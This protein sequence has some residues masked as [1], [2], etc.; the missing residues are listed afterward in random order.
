MTNVIEFRHAR[1]DTGNG[2]LHDFVSIHIDGRSLVEIMRELEAKMAEREGHPDLAGAYQPFVKPESAE[3]HYLGKHKER[4]GSSRT[5]TAIL[6]CECGCPG[7]WPLLC[8]IVIGTDEV[9]WIDFEQ[10]HRGANSKGSFWDYSSFAGFKFAKD[11]YLGSLAA[12]ER[13]RRR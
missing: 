9:K 5:K 4:W 6:E 8:E 3:I 11:Q 1:L 12:L 2:D 13:T 7:C 10:P